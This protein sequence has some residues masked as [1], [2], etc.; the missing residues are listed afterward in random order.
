MLLRDHNMPMLYILSVEE[1]EEEKTEDI[2][3]LDCVK[4]LLPP[5]ARF[6]NSASRS[7]HA[8]IHVL[9]R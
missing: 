1:K 9:R 5:A 4:Y 3:D 8:E 2:F 7:E 6:K